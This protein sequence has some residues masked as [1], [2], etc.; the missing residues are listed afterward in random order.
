MFEHH[1]EIRHSIVSWSWPRLPL[2]L[3]E[4]ERSG[5][6]G[7]IQARRAAGSEWRATGAAIGHGDQVCLVDAERNR[8]RFQRSFAAPPN[9]RRSRRFRSSSEANSG[10]LVLTSCGG[11]KQET[12]GFKSRFG[13][14]DRIARCLPSLC[15]PYLGGSSP[16]DDYP[17]V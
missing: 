16:G 13:R 4:A 5:R 1:D 9:I 14:P 15:G 7:T 3:R 8:K 17:F 12:V 6:S 11:A 2:H 10:A